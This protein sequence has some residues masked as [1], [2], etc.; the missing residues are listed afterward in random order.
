MTATA[1]NLGLELL[2]FSGLLVACFAALASVIDSFKLRRS[3]FWLRALLLP[4]LPAVLPGVLTLGDRVG[5]LG[6]DT[7]R[8][9]GPLVAVAC[10]FTLVVLPVFLY[11]GSRALPGESDWGDDPGQDPPPKPPDPP[12]GG[13]PLPDA[14]QSAER[15][16]DHSDGG[17]R[18]RRARR[19]ARER[20][21]TPTRSHR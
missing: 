6:D 16:R 21:R 20:K 1:R 2:M 5:V 15:R 18:R 17:R 14:D 7:L 8:A 19:S 11:R 13:I 9:V 4:V 12:A 10:A 3:H